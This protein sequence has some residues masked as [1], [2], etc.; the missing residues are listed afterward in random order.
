VSRAAP[1]AATTSGQVRGRVRRGVCQFRGIPFGGPTGGRQR[2]RPPGPVRPWTG[3]RDA[4]TFGPAFPQPM[5]DPDY[6][7]SFG[8]AP[9]T[10]M[11]EDG[12]TL[13]VCTPAVDDRPRPVMVYVHGGGYFSGAGSE[14]PTY[15]GLQL[16]RRHDLVVVTFNYRLGVFGFAHLAHLGVEGYASSGNVGMLDMIAALAWVRDNIA[17]FG[18]DPGNVTVFGS[19][20]GGHAVTSLLAMPEARGLFHRAVAQSGHAALCRDLE[21]ASRSTDALLDVLELRPRDVATGL[22]DLP[23]ARL[24]DAQSAAAVRL[25][26]DPMTLIGPVVDGVH[27]PMAP[28]DALGAG[29][30]QVP[31]LVGANGDEPECEAGVLAFADRLAGAGGAPVYVYR[32][33]VRATAGGLDS[34]CHGLE[35]PFVFADVDCPITAGI[36]HCDAIASVV[37]GA[38][39]AFARAGDPRHPGT[40][41]WPPY[42][43]RTRSVLVF[44][45]DP[46]ALSKVRRGAIS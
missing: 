36:P 2:F 7:A 42:S 6:L 19:S 22:V 11:S 17:S 38:W 4:T 43:R 18:G 35:L 13:N 25:G 33:A 21:T 15:D 40:P 23:A 37:S 30:A 5:A 27:L 45:Q 39:A 10:T 8:A 1:V 34:S 28:L 12:L 26:G 41:V 31:L 32:F 24:L 9:I 29:P 20:A 46:G 14:L 44:D 16:A 3:I